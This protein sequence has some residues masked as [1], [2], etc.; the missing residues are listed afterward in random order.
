MISYDRYQH[1]RVFQDPLTGR[2]RIETMV[3]PRLPRRE[4]DVYIYSTAGDR[5]DLMAY[6]YWGDAT[7]WFVIA[8]IN[9]V[10]N[11]SLAVAPGIQLRI[12]A[13]PNEFLDA[14]K[15]AQRR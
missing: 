2:R 3:F 13:S 4:D 12:P 11:G 14:L 8:A 7:L 9:N 10:G 1:N 15:E 6:D 5:L